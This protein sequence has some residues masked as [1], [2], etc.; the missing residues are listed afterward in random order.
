MGLF[1]SYVT[2]D[3]NMP[4]MLANLTGLLGSHYLLGEPGGWQ[5]L[6]PDSPL[7]LE[8]A[9]RRQA[10]QWAPP[11]YQ[12]FPYLPLPSTEPACPGELLFFLWPLYYCCYL[13]CLLHH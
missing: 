2:A 12:R 3:G 9:A 11:G 8:R 4:G 7:S 1:F 13:Y 6:A 5:H 10:W